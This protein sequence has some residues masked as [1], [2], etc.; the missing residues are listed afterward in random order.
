[1]DLPFKK[2]KKSHCSCIFVQI[3]GSAVGF[4][5]L[6]S[7]INMDLLSTCFELGPFHGL[8]VPD[9]SDI[10]DSQQSVSAGGESEYQWIC[11]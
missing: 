4:M 11:N 10:V 1:M 6:C 8:R 9:S 2:K 7:D 3:N 5:S